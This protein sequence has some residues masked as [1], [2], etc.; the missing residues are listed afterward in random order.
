MN[1]RPNY[2][3]A[4]PSQAARA[5]PAMASPV[6]R[7]SPKDSDSA[8]EARFKLYQFDKQKNWY[9][10]EFV[11]ELQKFYQKERSN[12]KY[13]IDTIYQENDTVKLNLLSQIDELRD[14][15]KANLKRHEQEIAEIQWARSKELLESITEKDQTILQ[16]KHEVYD[17]KNNYSKL[18]IEYSDL[19]EQYD[20]DKLSK[21]LS[22][23]N[24][25]IRFSA[26][27]RLI[28]F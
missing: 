25:N 3:T 4:L 24:Q 21:K 26:L 20:N 23:G 6:T 2:P 28:W 27:S 22:N 19:S 15:L 16:L 13:R 11:D 8:S 9:S 18:T 17:L 12:L 5:S 7:S 1:I 14:Q 10:K